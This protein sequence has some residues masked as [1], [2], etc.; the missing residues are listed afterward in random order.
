MTTIY[1]MSRISF[2]MVFI[3]GVFV[4]CVLD[5][6]ICLLRDSIAAAVSQ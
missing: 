1:D 6:K 5:N 4:I 2:I 3:G